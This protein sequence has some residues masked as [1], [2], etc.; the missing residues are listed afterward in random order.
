MS[1]AN[2]MGPAFMKRYLKPEERSVL[3]DIGYAVSNTYGNSLYTAN[4]YAYASSSCP[5]FQVAGIDDGINSTGGFSYSG[6]VSTPITISGI[7]TNDYPSS[8]LTFECMQVI[9]G[10]GSLSNTSGTSCVYTPT[11]SGIHLLRYVPVSSIG[12]KGNITYVYVYVPSANCTPSACDLVNNGGFEN[13]VNCGQENYD[14]PPPSANCW[15]VLSASPDLYVRGCIATS[16]PS[17]KVPTP[18]CSP[19][20]DTRDSPS[21]TN[22]NMIG[23]WSK[24]QQWGEA[25][26]NNLSSFIAAGTSYVLSF[27][28]K[29]ENAFSG[30]I[31]TTLVFGGSPSP[32]APIYP[33]VATPSSLTVLA[34]IVVPNNNAWN[35]YSVTITNTSSTNLNYLSIINAAYLYAAG[36]ES[37]ILI[38]DIS[39]VPFSSAPSFSPP[40]NICLGGSITDLSPYASPP[41]GSFSGS[42]VSLSGG[43]YSFAAATLGNN[44][45]AYTYTNNLGCVKSI[46]GS[47]NV[48]SSITTVTVTPTATTVCAGL[49]TILTASGPSTYSWSTGVITNTV[50]VSSFSTTVYTVTG[51]S[52]GCSGTS[53]GT[54]T[55]TI[56]PGPTVSVTTSSFSIC[57]STSTTLTALGATSYS[58]SPSI[59]LSCI[60]CSSPVAT[61]STTTVYTVSGSTGGCLSFPQTVTV[62][63]TPVPSLTVTQAPIVLCTGQTATL[64]AIGAT[65]YTWS[66]G[67]VGPV[68][69]GSF[70]AAGVK[71]Y[72]ITANTLGCTMVKTGSV[73]VNATPTITIAPISPTVCYGA[74]SMLT[75]SGASSYT[76]TPGT[77]LSCSVCVN[78]VASPTTNTTY[79]LT[80]T[81]GIPR[82]KWTKIC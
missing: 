24:S 64:T 76:W 15:T 28:A 54:A 37:S 68:A 36:S 66:N 1:N 2:G 80:G 20:S 31:P 23:L 62:N 10:S 70:A 14:T 46:G 74:N 19:A 75:A 26:Q 42:G 12:N 65:T 39:I 16:D 7:L 44:L 8:G 82:K 25:Y 22:N 6:A 38:D 40:S 50:N 55:V 21:V 78:P 56:T 18:R 69:T 52:I 77:A 73:T 57:P 29:V 53:I 51:T 61:P 43:I 11:T 41:G 59:S 49:P 17:I 13:A 3:C 35:T 63:V 45:I 5:G 27:A 81:S 71:S 33:I 30:N 9:I 34:S 79:T 48:T 58:W 32:L 72:T 4:N 60:N 47:I 67:T